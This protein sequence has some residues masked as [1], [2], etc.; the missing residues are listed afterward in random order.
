MSETEMRI[1]DVSRTGPMATDLRSSVRYALRAKAVFRWTDSSGVAC[2]AQGYTRDL[3][4]RGAFIV[5]RQWPPVGVLLTLTIYLQPP[6]GPSKDLRM[7]AKGKVLRVELKSVPENSPGFA[8]QNRW[9]R[10]E[11]AV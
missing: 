9:M 4:A 1:S 7:Q 6:S 10:Y 5:C 3:S 2:E 8:V 11:G